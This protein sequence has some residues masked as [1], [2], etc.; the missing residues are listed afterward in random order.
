MYRPDVC[1]L[2]QTM[3]A[4]NRL[5][6]PTL[7]EID[8]AWNDYR[9]GQAGGAGIVDLISF[10]VMRRLGITQAFTNDEHFSLAGFELLF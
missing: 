2:R 5:I 7:Q 6:E 9:A 3:L 1:D 8:Q 4:E 10:G